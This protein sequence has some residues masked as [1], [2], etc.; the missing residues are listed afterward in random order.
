MPSAEQ[1][2]AVLEEKDILPPEVLGA[3][4]RTLRETAKPPAAQALADWLVRHGHLTPSMAERLLAAGHPEGTRRKA[5]GGGTASPRTDHTAVP[6]GHQ[7]PATSHQPLPGGFGLLDELPPLGA[8]GGGPLDPLLAAGPIDEAQG[9][10]LGPARRRRWSLRRFAKGLRRFFREPRRSIRNWFRRRSQFV[11][12]KPADPRK[13]KLLLF[14]WGLA[15]ALMATA[16][17][18]FWYLS[19]PSPGELVRRADV[20]YDDGQYAEAIECW[21]IF[22]NKYAYEPRV[23]EVRVRRSLAELRA[24]V[25]EARA[26]DD[27]T[28]AFE[29]AQSLMKKLP[30]EP[31]YGDWQKEVGEVLGMIGEGLARQAAQ[32][33]TAAVVEQ[34]RRVVGMIEMNVGEP[35][36]PSQAIAEIQRLLEGSQREVNRGH[37]LEETLSA[38]A[39]ALLGKDAVTAYAARNALVARH[40]DLAEDGRLEEALGPAAALLRQAVKMVP[41]AVGATTDE[42]SAGIL[43]SRAMAVR[44]V[45][46][47]VP[48][49]KGR[50]VFAATAGVAYGLD[51]ASGRLLWRRFIAAEKGAGP[52]SAK[53]R[54]AFPPQTLGDDP[55]GDLLLTDPVHNEVLRVQGATGRLV[56]RQAIGRRIV[57]APVRAGNRLL[58]PTEQGQLV[59]VDLATGASPGH[60]ELPQPL[61]V[62]PTVDP[63]RSLVFQVADQ[64]TLYVLSEDDWTCRQVFHLG[65][66]R[67]AVA[68]PPVIAGG[69][70]L[71]VENAGAREATLRV[72]GLGPPGA[73]QGELKSLQHVALKG[74]VTTPPLVDG[75]RVAVVTV[76]GIVELFKLAPATRA[77]SAGWSPLERVARS[78][79]SGR[80]EATRYLLA[81]DNRWWVADTQLARYEI[82]AEGGR[83][84]PRQI[85]D[86][87]SKFIQPPV[88][89]GAVMYHFCRRPGMPGVMVSAVDPQT[90]EP[91]W[92]T[93][94]AAPL[95]GEP[96]TDAPSGS[97]TAVTASGGV[98][99]FPPASFQGNAPAD[100]PVLA[101]E[102]DKLLQSVREATPLGGGRFALT[103]GSGSRP[104]VLYDPAEHDKRFRW[105][106]APEPMASAPLALASGLLVPSSTGN[107]FLLDLQSTENP[108]KP[109]RPLLASVT[110]WKWSPPQ[111]V[112][113]QAALLCDGDRRLYLVRL[114]SQPEAA[115]IEVASA[116]TSTAIVAP[117]VVV[118][119]AGKLGEALGAAA[120]ARGVAFLVAGS[121]VVPFA[122]PNL[123][124]G[125]PQ[126][127]EGRCIWGPRRAGNVVLLATDK[128][129]LYCLG[130][131][132]PSAAGQKGLLSP[133]PAEKPQAAPLD[134]S[135]GV[136][137]DAGTAPQAPSIGRLLWTAALPYGCPVGAPLVADGFIYLAA[138]GGTVWRIAAETGREA[139]KTESGCPLGTG[140][141]LLDQRLFVAT[142][143]GCLLEVNRP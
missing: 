15:V 46:G 11:Q 71:V 13:V 2:L 16:F 53:P 35:Q 125:Q 24:A 3:L 107:V 128:R 98:F 9:P 79:L 44:T 25:E 112:G 43:A 84:V 6:T 111:A 89:L 63:Q 81:R 118:S 50:S 20:A 76:Q 114:Q 143:D 72:L 28:T 58:V 27:W 39:A 105:L 4:R 108:A 30:D 131:A 1:F 136:N 106:V 96:L 100:Q 97:L 65:Q 8:A 116:T 60:I 124:E 51:A 34:A 57:A 48:G 130:A 127:L 47:E 133:S 94:L 92:Q 137:A 41:R 86:R 19:P 12:V 67:D 102:A 56:W 5:E 54:P 132:Q 142:P 73:G 123:T 139:G 103:M 49:A 52:V 36:R 109:F 80:E 82:E 37:D 29:M 21:S 122:L 62:S 69:Y 68:A 74:R 32:Q 135:A 120:A 70:L 101:V 138:E 115:L 95:A 64:S 110:A 99:R 113:R 23:A 7:P 75:Q 93:W 129:R 85:S 22:L 31:A 117:P 134:G 91:V 77:P 55:A 14:S 87:L 104:I 18:V 33:P 66:Q 61:G 40:Q 119:E 141:V 45:Q 83:L 90:D 10:G 59:L 38:V 26:V 88:L 78:E 121:S 126:P 17:G 140:P 42:R